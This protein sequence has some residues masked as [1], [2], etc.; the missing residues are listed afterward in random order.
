MTAHLYVLTSNYAA[1]V[2]LIESF[3]TRLEKSEKS[4]DLDIRYSP[5]LVAL[6]ASIYKAQ[7]RKASI[8]EELRKASSFWKKKAESKPKEDIPL[9]LLRAAG[10]SLLESEDRKDLEDASSI[11]T[12]LSERDPSSP[13]VA[14]GLVASNATVYPERIS[15]KQLSALPDT[16]RVTEKIDAVA[17]EDAGVAKTK[18]FALSSIKK[19]PA[20][21]KDKS[22][23]PKKIRKSRM[24]KDFVES[25]KMDPE[26][27]MPMR[28]RSYYRPKGKKGKKKQEA[29]TQG[30]VVAEEK[31][32]GTETPKQVVGG[33]NQKKKKKGK[34]GKR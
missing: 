28:D 21:D 18:V 23:R 27:W 13:A 30:G 4:S 5:G 2:S 19:R 24:P 8:R 3:F 1:A 6:L 33:G 26:R 12:I 15:Q 34:G 9:A 7:S 29:L 11:Y 14:A 22:P 32:S 17:L 25:K 16:S 10:A 31:A 20:A